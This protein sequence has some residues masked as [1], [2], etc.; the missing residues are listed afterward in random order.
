M[1][2]YVNNRIEEFLDVIQRVARGDYT[3]S[4]GLTEKNDVF[5]ALGMG[6]NMMT[7][8]IRNVI[9]EREQIARELQKQTYK[10]GERV[11]EMLCLYAVSMLVEKQD[12]SL[13]GILQGTV[14]LIP[15]AYRYPEITCAQIAL[16]GQT[17]RTN[18]FEETILKQS[19]DI[20]VRGSKVGSLEVFYLEEKPEC[21]E[22]PFLNEE[23]ELINAIVERLGRIVERKRMDE[24]LK[25]SDERFKII[26]DNISDGLLLADLENR[27]F[28]TGN[29]TIRQMLGY[30][31]IEEIMNLGIMDIHPEEDLPYV[32]EQFERQSK[33]ELTLAKDIPVKRKDGSV[34]YADISSSPP[35][36][37]AG[38]TYLVG[39]FRDITEHKKMEEE[40]RKTLETLAAEKEARLRELEKTNKMKTDFL[41]MLAHEL[42]SPLTPITAYLSLLID[43]DL[44]ALTEQQKDGLEAIIRNVKRMRALIWN[45]LD[46]TKLESGRVEFKMGKVQLSD[47]IETTVRDMDL[48]AE[49]K[50]VS[51]SA[52]PP[53]LPFIHGDF[54]RLAQ[55]F[56]NLLDNAIRFTPEKG[57]VRIEA[58]LVND[59][60]LVKIEDT[61]LG[62]P[63][64]DIERV[65]EKFYRAEVALNHQIEG[66][67]LGL[68]ICKQ[69]V[70][71]H[72]GRIWIESK[73]GKGTTVNFTLPIE[74]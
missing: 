22:G 34:F 72:G 20:I 53:Q 32:I 68:T 56:I 15:S 10:L 35:L 66:T 70:E 40:R 43:E 16:E 71:K 12:I 67:G 33:R 7:D 36:T 60:V 14:D 23:R 19:A 30:D 44:G 48:L 61:G 63:K 73:L 31:S 57:R 8:D 64:K 11:K 18:S 9:E 4:C 2:K 39:I 6:I 37:L 21:D 50:Q 69:I 74:K 46:V 29:E 49:K 45:V 38:K 52:K 62:I 54:N 24:M 5:D 13:G 28:F 42:K 27:K 59:K 51:L 3:V 26:F 25:E 55:V 58:T 17:F 41:D 1:L 47:I 65:F